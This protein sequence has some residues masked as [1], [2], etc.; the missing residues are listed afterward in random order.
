M[1]TVRLGREFLDHDPARPRPGFF[2][3]EQPALQLLADLAMH[4]QRLAVRAPFGPRRNIPLLRGLWIEQVAGERAIREAWGAPRFY[5]QPPPGRGDPGVDPDLAVFVEGEVWISRFRRDPDTPKP[6][7]DWM[8]TDEVRARLEWEDLPEDT[9]RV[10]PKPSH[11]DPGPGQLF[12]LLGPVALFTEEGLREQTGLVAAWRRLQEARIGRHL[13]A[14][15][16]HRHKVRRSPESAAG[17]T[18]DRYLRLCPEF[19]PQVALD[20]TVY[21]EWRKGAPGS[22]DVASRARARQRVRMRLERAVNDGRITGLPDAVSPAWWEP[23]RHP[24]ALRDAI[25]RESAR[26]RPA[27]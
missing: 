9:R 2:S 10:T 14:Q 20:A 22:E 11:T 1:R 17:E 21:M 15:D 12:M 6:D 27:S 8:S 13:L 18:V 25:R 3:D 23:G 7:Y 19:G 16:V 26:G 24:E 5:P 4:I